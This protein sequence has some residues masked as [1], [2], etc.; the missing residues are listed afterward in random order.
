MHLEFANSL[1]ELVRLAHGLEDF[2]KTEGL[3]AEVTSALNLALEELMTNI[4]SHGYGPGVDGGIW[5]DLQRDGEQVKAVLRDKAAAFNPLQ[6]PAPDLSSP[7][8]TRPV[9]GLGIHLV[10]ELMD[11]WDYRREGS[12]N[13]ITLRKNVR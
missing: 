11:D 4:H 6:A 13:V 12:E 2:A 3:S 9:G 5:L 10:K 7:V 1:S 8:E